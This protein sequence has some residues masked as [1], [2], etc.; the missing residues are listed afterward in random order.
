MAIIS[1]QHKRV[2]VV[3][4]SRGGT[5]LLQSIIVQHPRFKGFPE[6]NILYRAIGDIQV[7]RYGKWVLGKTTTAKLKLKALRNKVGYTGRPVGDIF[8]E[9]FS[10]IGRPDLNYLSPGNSH[11]MRIIFRQFHAMLDT[12]SGGCP[13]VE[14][15]PQH[16]FCL[17]YLQKY[18]KEAYFIHIV[19]D[20]KDNIAS[21]I[22]AGQ[23]YPRFRRRFGGRDGLK[24][25]V[26]YWNNSLMSSQKWMHHK[27]HLVIR[28]EDIIANP[29]KALS[30]LEKLLNIQFTDEMLTYNTNKIT[31]VTEL[32]KIRKSNKI[33]VPENKFLSVLIPEQ[34]QFILKNTF[35]ADEIFPRQFS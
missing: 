18:F 20:G 32:W 9:F 23:K 8:V 13:W 21:L 30:G 11:S 2:F 5:T 1:D 28:F 24:K 4:C 15:T 7:R 27:N 16:I 31:F 26:A 33:E 17:D 25:A 12:L 14:K 35:S 34:Q 3:G 6:T 22:D 19:R 29:K 10:H